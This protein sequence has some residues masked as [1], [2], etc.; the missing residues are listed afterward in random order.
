MIGGAIPFLHAALLQFHANFP[1]RKFLHSKHIIFIGP[2]GVPVKAFKFVGPLDE[3][4]YIGARIAG[5]IVVAAGHIRNVGKGFEEFG[6]GHCV[7]G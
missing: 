2:I 1:H 3:V 5:I 4:G 7:K 6:G